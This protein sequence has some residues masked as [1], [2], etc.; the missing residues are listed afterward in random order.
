[1]A[2]PTDPT[3][4]DLAG[5]ASEVHDIDLSQAVVGTDADPD[6][7]RIFIL[8]EVDGGFRFI[9]YGLDANGK[10]ASPEEPLFIPNTAIGDLQSLFH[11]AGL[12]RN[13][14]RLLEFPEEER[15]DLQE[16][17]EAMGLVHPM[18]EDPG[19]H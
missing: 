19:D 18:G 6:S 5:S 9:P 10:A 17:G 13:E 15:Q 3:L 1:M 8:E 14:Q 12:R 11:V 16:I 7:K 4:A 2:D